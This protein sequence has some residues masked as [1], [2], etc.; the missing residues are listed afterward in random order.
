MTAP[1][2]RRELTA[3]ERHVDIRGLVEALEQAKH[4]L[5]AEIQREQRRAARAVIAGRRANLVITPRMAAILARLYQRGVRAAIDES[6]S[7]GVALRKALE[8]EPAPIPPGTIRPYQRLRLLL[9]ELSRRLTGEGAARLAIQAD[10]RPEM[11]RALIRVPGALDAAGRVVS[12][13]LTSGLSDVYSANEDAFSGWQYTA[14]LDGGTCD[15]CEAR[16]GEEYATLTEGL[17]VLPDF[18]PNPLCFGETRCRCRLLP[19]GAA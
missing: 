12:M 11:L 7:M 10:S 17:E 1:A 13:T 9:G 19:L 2:L 14:V 15:E 6:A 5:A 18:G 3:A 8:A 4:D 16:D